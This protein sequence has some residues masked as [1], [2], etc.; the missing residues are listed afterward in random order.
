MNAFAPLQIVYIV[1]FAASGAVSLA[2]AYGVRTRYDARGTK[3]LAYALATVGLWAF[4]SAARTAAS[5]PT[6]TLL[7]L[8]TEMFFAIATARLWFVFAAQYTN[9]RIHRRRWVQ[10]ALYALVAAAL[11]VP[12]SNP[13]HGLMWERVTPV[14]EP[15]VHYDVVK[16]PA[17]YVLT[18]TGY[19][20]VAV[21][22]SYLVRMLRSTSHTRAVAS[23]IVG[24]L[25]L[26]SANATPYLVETGITHSTTI[27]PLG[28]TLFCF[29]SAVAIRNNL[30]SVTPVGRAR[31]FAA[32]QDPVVML[33]RNRRV[34]D[35]NPA[36]AAAFTDGADVS[37]REFSEAAPAL[38]AAL[39]DPMDGP[40]H[41]SVAGEEGNERSYTVT[42]SPLESGPH[43]LG[44]VLV[45]RDITDLLTSQLELARKDSQ[46][47]EFSDSVAHDLR[48][49][50]S[51]IVAHVELLRAH[52]SQVDAGTAAYDHHLAVTSLDRL[53]D[54]SGRMGAI[55]DDFLRVTREANS[56]RNVEPLDFERFLREAASDHLP[57][58]AVSVPATG[59][60]YAS[61]PHADLLLDAVFRNVAHRAGDD[62][63]VTARLTDEG[64]V[65]EDTGEP[66]PADEVESLL[67]YG[68][69]TRFRGEG[70][71]LSVAKTLAEAHNWSIG[72]D[73]D[74]RDGLRVVVSGVTTDVAT[75]K[76]DEPPTPS[77]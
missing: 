70:L 52:L 63:A 76:T 24:F 36:F 56:P 13:W 64:F 54:H 60:L 32:I 65:V 75:G 23:L 27:T 69:T 74:Y 44:R 12:L 46:L 51:V 47:D 35:H 4:N 67:A 48:N 41:V 16:G 73:T 58:D 71:G 34:I 42:A 68:Y 30:F 8:A 59:T 5:D 38:E 26:V 18:V 33:D 40:E 11:V 49:P 17:H 25:L 61:P 7:L 43:T 15:F 29:M 45:F 53:D 3:T 66:V 19:A 50:L 21:G 10:L 37:H 39:D 55:I 72:V 20:L 14:G 22:L 1:V 9:R 6:V 57:A 2:F 31:V 28:G 62:L 77:A